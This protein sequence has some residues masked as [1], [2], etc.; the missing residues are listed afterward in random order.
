MQVGAG[1]AGCD[2]FAGSGA[3]FDDLGKL[4][5]LLG[6]EEGDKPDFIEVLTD[7]I[8]HGTH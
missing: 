5:L 7:G 4:A 2:A 3:R 1:L 8:A 6:G